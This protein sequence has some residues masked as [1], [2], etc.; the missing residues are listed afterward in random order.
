[1]SKS[2]A[3]LLAA[4]AVSLLAAGGVA[5]AN[6]M[7][8]S[9][10]EPNRQVQLV[11]PAAET[12]TVTPTVTATTATAVPKKVAPKPA[13]VESTTSAAVKKATTIQR[14]AVVSEP[15]PETTTSEPSKPAPFGTASNGLPK[16][17]PVDF[18]TQDKPPTSTN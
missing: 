13:P 15:A 1:M 12:V 6:L 16:P 9:A 5:G 10:P 7:R 11:Q 18:G 3:P 8:S 17:P 2:A 4:V 14:Q